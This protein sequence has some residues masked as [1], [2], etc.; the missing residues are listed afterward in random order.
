MELKLI[1]V[2]LMLQ[3]KQNHQNRLTHH[4]LLVLLMMLAAGGEEMNEVLGLPD[5]VVAG[6]FD[7]QK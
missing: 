6:R 7:H 4:L 3:I 1:W 5:S 2:L